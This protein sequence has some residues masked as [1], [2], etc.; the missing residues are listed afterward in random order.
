VQTDSRLGRRMLEILMLGIS[1]RNYRKVLPE[2]AET[3]GLSSSFVP[4][5]TIHSSHSMGSLSLW[6]AQSTTWDCR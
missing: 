1:T 5:T 2:M 3:A 6:S 4:R